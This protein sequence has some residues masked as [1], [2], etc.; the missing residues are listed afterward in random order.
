MGQCSS[1]RPIHQT[2]YGKSRSLFFSLS[3]F[4]A[5]EIKSCCF[6]F[7]LSRSDVFSLSGFATF[8]VSMLLCLPS[9]MLYFCFVEISTAHKY[10]PFSK[11][12]IQSSSIPNSRALD[13]DSGDACGAIR[14]IGIR[15]LQESRRGSVLLLCRRNRS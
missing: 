7:N 11:C 6:S 4:L 2:V 15:T 14:H 5:P 3:S 8:G 9:I 13:L 12:F 10:S 1:H